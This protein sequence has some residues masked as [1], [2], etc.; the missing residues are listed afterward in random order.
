MRDYQE[1]CIYN[2]L[3]SLVIF[4]MKN[5]FFF[6]AGDGIRERVR[7]RGLGNV[8]KREKRYMP[9]CQFYGL[10]QRRLLPVRP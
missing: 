7:S 5:I 8:Y 9:V 2:E 3:Y 1:K 10:R 6:Q 4:F